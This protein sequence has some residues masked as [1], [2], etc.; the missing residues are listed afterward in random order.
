L[1]EVK[2]V[3]TKIKVIG[4]FVL[5]L[6]ALALFSG[7]LTNAEQ[8][9][10][11]VTSAAVSSSE[12]ELKGVTICFECHDAEQTIGFHYPAT[13]KG[14]EEKK[15]LRQRLCFDC[16]GRDG[17]DPDKAMTDPSQIEWI[18]EKG[19]F[20]VNDATVHSIHREKLDKEI[21]M[22]ETCHLIK[23]GDP[24][25]LGDDVIMPVPNPGQVL[26]CAMCHV[27]RDPGNY[28]SIHIISGHQECITCHTGDLK[29]IH[30]RATENLGQTS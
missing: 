15:G 10:A 24:T 27:P 9:A 23:E 28:I 14:I 6:V 29:T 13:I 11:P 17:T 8:T 16:H 22:C 25:K 20:K 1:L 3:G 26:V 2:L 12:I 4:L 5:S 19:Y 7:I 21:M 30:K 18:E